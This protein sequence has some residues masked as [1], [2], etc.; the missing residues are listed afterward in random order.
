MN[1]LLVL[2]VV[3]RKAKAGRT[4]G[5]NGTSDAFVF[6]HGSALSR[7][8][9][10]AARGVSDDAE[11]AALGVEAAHV[12]IGELF[13]AEPVQERVV[14]GRESII[15]DLGL[16]AAQVHLDQRHRVGGR[17]AGC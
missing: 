4:V 8:S 2:I 13:V 5:D 10:D 6:Q 14:E 15:N 16:T 12:Q 9:G 17:T 1:P 11:N 7:S 3:T